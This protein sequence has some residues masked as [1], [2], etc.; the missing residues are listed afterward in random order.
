MSGYETIIILNK[1]I[2]RKIC[3]IGCHRS[4]NISRKIYQKA[5]KILVIRYLLMPFVAAYV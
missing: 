1:G 4:M 5:Y 2:I 3:R